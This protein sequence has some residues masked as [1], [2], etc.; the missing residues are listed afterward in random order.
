MGFGKYN[1][2]GSKMKQLDVRLGWIE[3]MRECGHLSWL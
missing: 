1:G 3:L 2:G